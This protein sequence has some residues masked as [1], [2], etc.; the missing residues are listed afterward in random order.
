MIKKTAEVKVKENEDISPHVNEFIKDYI[1]DRDIHDAAVSAPLAR[2]TE[3]GKNMLYGLGGI[4]QYLQLEKI[5][6]RS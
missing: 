5:R 2:L 1:H 4:L 3:D 6:T